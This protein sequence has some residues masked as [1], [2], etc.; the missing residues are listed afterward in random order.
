MLQIRSI[1]A[2]TAASFF[3]MFFLGIG[4]TVIGAASKNIGLTPFEIGLLIAVQNLGFMIAVMVS[5]VAADSIEKPRILFVGSVVLACGFF[6]FYMKDSFLIN[7]FIMFGIGLGIG[8]YEGTSDAMLLDIHDTK[9]SLF[10]TINHFFV[11]LGA[12]IITGYLV[13][14]QMNW[15]TATIQAAI[16]LLVLAVIFLLLKVEKHTGGE[17]KLAARLRFLFKQR[18]V[19]VLVVLAMF[20]VGLEMGTIGML[21]SFLMDFKGYT[22][23]TSKL[24]LLTFLVG[25]AGGRLILGFFA[26][27]HRIL[28]FVTVLFGGAV[29]A[30]SF[31]YFI[32]FGA[33]VTYILMFCFGAIVSVLLPLVISL[34][35]ILHKEMA[36][37]VLGIIKIGIPIGGVVIP[38]LFSLITKAAGF[39][40]ALIIFPVISA[41]SFILAL[42]LLQR[43]RIVGT[44]PGS[45]E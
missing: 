28:L 32:D 1:K 40:E 44:P 2:A 42:V 23:V 15:R 35:G 31:L 7:L 41:L 13:F 20:C 18:E 34:G 37:T 9:E 11:T 5:G 24:G 8:T 38:G 22:Q 21:T 17:Q 14:L 30:S 6:F 43:Q 16:A 33:V 26:E 25:L 10:I 3:S 36:G 12:L 4:G 29:L 19:L 39:R 27:K 45:A